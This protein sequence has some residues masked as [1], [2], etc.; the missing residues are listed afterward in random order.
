MASLCN[1]EDIE[2]DPRYDNEQLTDVLA[3]EP[4]ADASRSTEGSGE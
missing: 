3:D 4:T 2:L 1:T